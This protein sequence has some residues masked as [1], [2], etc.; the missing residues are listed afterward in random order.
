MEVSDGTEEFEAE[1][2][3]AP[4]LSP[5]PA[6]YFDA[7]SLLLRRLQEVSRIVNGNLVIDR[8]ALASAG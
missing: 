1:F 4:F 2:G 3:V 6:L 8:A 5:L 7:A